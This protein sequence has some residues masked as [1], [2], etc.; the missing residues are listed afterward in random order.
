MSAEGA[1]LRTALPELVSTLGV[2]PLQ[3]ILTASYIFKVTI[4]VESGNTEARC[5]MRGVV[6]PTLRAVVQEFGNCGFDT[7]CPGP[8]MT[9]VG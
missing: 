6:C 9:T 8:G 3:V 7:A 2:P 5:M 4:P 1:E